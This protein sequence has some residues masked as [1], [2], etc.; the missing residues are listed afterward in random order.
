ML[1][2]DYKTTPITTAIEPRSLDFIYDT[3]GVDVTSLFPLL[4]E[5]HHVIS[6]AALPSGND[7]KS[8]MPVIPW[9]VSTPL[10]LLAKFKLEG[11]AARAG[12]HYHYHIMSPNGADLEEIGKLVEQGKIKPVIG[13]VFDFTEEG[14]RTACE[15]VTGNGSKNGGKCVIKIV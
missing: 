14:C 4:K 3:A 10:N 15:L 1:V 5:D 7:L 6:I 9:Y 11:P 2:I 8:Q 13:D 12:V